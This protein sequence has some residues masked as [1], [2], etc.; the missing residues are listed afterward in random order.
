MDSSKL[1]ER[2][3]EKLVSVLTPVRVKEGDDELT[4]FHIKWKLTSSKGVIT[5]HYAFRPHMLS[6]VIEDVLNQHPMHMYYRDSVIALYKAESAARA[7]LPWK[8]MTIPWPKD[9]E[10]YPN[11]LE[12]YV[13]VRDNMLNLARKSKT[14]TPMTGTEIIEA[15]KKIGPNPT[16]Y[17]DPDPKLA[18]QRSDLLV[19]RLWGV[20]GIEKS[21]EEIR[22]ELI[23]EIQKNPVLLMATSWFMLSAIRDHGIEIEDPDLKK[24]PEVKTYLISKGVVRVSK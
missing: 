3:Y 2:M 4:V 13:R 5:K 10:D 19:N 12:D 20:K 8:G 6:R 11:R 18:K 23:S 15:L 1:V 7:G 22:E 16:Q 17:L 24:N 14:W 21:P 9:T